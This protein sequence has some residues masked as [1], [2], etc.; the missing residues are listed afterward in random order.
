MALLAQLTWDL[1]PEI[2]SIGNFALRWY[3]VCFAAG[4]LA[5]FL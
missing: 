3:G 5:G 1:D 4:F 2:F